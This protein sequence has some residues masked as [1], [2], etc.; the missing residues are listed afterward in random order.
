MGSLSKEKHAL[1]LLIVGL[2]G[3]VVPGGGYFLLKEKKRA[4]IILVAIVLTFAIGLYVG[5]VGV[6]DPIGSKAWYC[7]QV[8]TSPLVFFLG[9]MTAVGEYV[10]YGRPNEIGQIYT[11]IAG[12]LN[13]LVIVNTVYLAHVCSLEEKK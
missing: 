7:A 12:L 5:S 1:S 9:N 8:L 10:V 11:S 4:T 13:L 3:W 2:A 6:V